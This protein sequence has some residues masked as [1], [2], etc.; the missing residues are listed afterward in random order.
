M[1]PTPA[2]R[3]RPRVPPRRA[4]KA[5]GGWPRYWPLAI[6]LIITPFA[7]H[8]ASILALEGPKPLAL[9][10]PWVEVVS[11]PLLQLSAAV[12]SRLSQWTL[13]LQFPLYGLIM[14]VA[15][16]DDKP[17]RA[18]TTGLIAHFIGLVLA[19]SLAYFAQ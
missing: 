3:R 9:L 18:F 19:V 7:I 6:C 8:G 1:S 5:H 4:P 11:S 13:Y 10:F 12:V 15:W 16:R 2:A 14:T 17:G